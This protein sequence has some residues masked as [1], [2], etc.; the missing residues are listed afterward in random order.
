M[1]AFKSV[2]LLAILFTAISAFSLSQSVLQRVIIGKWKY[3]FNA[4]ISAII[5]F[6]A[7]G[8]ATQF[9]QVGSFKSVVHGTYKVNGDVLITTFAGKTESNKVD[10]DTDERIVIKAKYIYTRVR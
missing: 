2:F 1:K 6:R 3:Q 9:N 5:E 7:N 10:S 4:Q 8:T